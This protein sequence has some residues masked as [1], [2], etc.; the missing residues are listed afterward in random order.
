M[1]IATAESFLDT[2]INSVENGTVTI[3]TLQL[4]EKHSSQFLKLGEIHQKNKKVP[5]PVKDSYLQRRSEKK[6]FFTL[7]DNLE[8]F[9]NFS[10]IFTSGTVYKKFKKN[11]PSRPA[12][13]HACSRQGMVMNHLGNTKLMYTVLLT[14]STL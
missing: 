10:N 7:R 13:I 3:A 1:I 12:S 14:Y 5:V 6:A 11:S 2:L 4:L 8:C 9:I